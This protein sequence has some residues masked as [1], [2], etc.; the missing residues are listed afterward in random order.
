MPAFHATQSCMAFRADQ[1]EGGGVCICIEACMEGF[2]EA[3]KKAMRVRTSDF[4]INESPGT[5]DAAT[6]GSR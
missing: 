2:A 6:R 5:R 1:G 4:V 3:M